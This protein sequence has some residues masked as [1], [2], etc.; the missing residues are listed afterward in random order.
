MFLTLVE[1]LEPAWMQCPRGKFFDTTKN[2][3]HDSH[4]VICDYNRCDGHG[5]GLV[6]SGKNWCHNYIQCEDDFPVAEYTCPN[7][8][9]FD[10]TIQ[11]CVPYIIEHLGCDKKA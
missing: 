3:C 10:Q 1:D 4:N 11:A 8:W 6:A 2:D 9:F 5:N 7:D